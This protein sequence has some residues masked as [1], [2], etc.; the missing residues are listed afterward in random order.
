MDPI[1]NILCTI[2]NGISAKKTYV[3]LPYGKIGWAI[4]HVLYLYGYIHGMGI[5]LFGKHKRIVVVLLPQNEYTSYTKFTRICL[6]YT[7]PSP[8]DRG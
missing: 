8:R 1:S 7:S 3:S 4:C 5:Q 2:R 6:L